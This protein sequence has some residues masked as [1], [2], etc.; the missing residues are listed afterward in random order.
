M[1]WINQKIYPPK[2]ELDYNYKG[3]ICDFWDDTKYY[4]DLDQNVGTTQS[5]LVDFS[6]TL[7]QDN[8]DTTS[9]AVRFQQQKHLHYLLAILIIRALFE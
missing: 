7:V 4:V 6:T 5:T 1:Q 9:G 8:Q 3:D 2:G